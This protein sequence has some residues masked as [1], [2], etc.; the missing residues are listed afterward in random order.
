MKLQAST[1]RRE[2]LPGPL[3][4]PSNTERVEQKS[5]LLTGF[6]PLTPAVATGLGLVLTLPQSEVGPPVQDQPGG[7]PFDNKILIEPKH[8]MLPQ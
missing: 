3:D 4:Q 6:R 5:E 1:N 8:G 7:D 2:Q